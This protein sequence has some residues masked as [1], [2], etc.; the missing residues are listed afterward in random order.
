MMPRHLASVP[1]AVAGTGPP[2]AAGTLGG[3]ADE[4]AEVAAGAAADI[5]PAPGAGAPDAAEMKAFT[6]SGVS[7]AKNCSIALQCFVE[8]TGS[9]CGLK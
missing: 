1:E 8:A 2:T 9:S 4:A 6:C 7:V 3:E 5:A